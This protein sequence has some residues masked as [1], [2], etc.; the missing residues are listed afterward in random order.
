[1]SRRRVLVLGASRY[2]ARSIRTVHEMG[3]EVVAIDRN[4][5]AEGF[6]AADH[7]EAVDITDA[8]GVVGVARRYRVDA[9]LPLND[10]GVPAAAAAVEALNLIGIDRATAAR[11]TS[12]SLMRGAWDAAGVPNPGWRLV[13][14]LREAEQAASEL[15]SWP[16]IVKPDDSRGGAS[17]GV[18]VIHRLAELPE[19]LAQAQAIY[20]TAACV[21]EEFL[22]GVEHSVET[23]TVSG[24]PHVIAVSDKVK[25]PLPWRVDKS[26]DYPTRLEGEAL[27]R[28]HAVVKRAVEAL[29]ITAGAAHVELCT[30]ADGPKL[31]ELGAR[32]GGGGTPDPIVPYVSGV[33]VLKEVVR[34]SLGD[35]PKQLTPTQN[36]GC[37]YRFLT[38][39]PG[40]LREVRGLDEVRAWPGIL[41]CDVLAAPGD[42]ILEVQAGAAR[43]GFV[44]AGG[45]TRAAAVALADRAE[46]HIEFA[47]E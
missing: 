11:A 34:V 9:V 5:A 40:R 22:E 4:P 43:A 27:D 7:H 33:E 13:R 25:T 36:R 15:A 37:S 35:A 32:C 31:F 23:V 29:G 41:D 12:K 18:K 20:G 8:E 21:I 10:F 28:L 46:R 24:T 26:V 16:L 39:P 3:C 38:P 47:V 30:T 44:I 45:P 1:M 19:A 6:A 17:R 42:R 2:Y 14:T